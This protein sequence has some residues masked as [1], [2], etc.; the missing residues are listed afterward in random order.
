MIPVRREL[1]PS[2]TH[3]TRAYWYCAVAGV[4]FSGVIVIEQGEGKTLERDVYAVE[5][6]S[7]AEL[8]TE[9][10]LAVLRRYFAVV[11]CG[12]VDEGGSPCEGLYLVS[13]PDAMAPND[14]RPACQCFGY[15]RHQNCKHIDALTDLV[16]VQREQTQAK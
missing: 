12:P 8:F 7:V 5:E 10:N 9:S 13:I 1:A 3:E 6:L 16:R 11:K 2:L 14:A 15:N 4:C